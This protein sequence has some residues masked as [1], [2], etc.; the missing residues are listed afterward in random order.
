MQAGDHIVVFADAAVVDTVMGRLR[1]RSENWPAEVRDQ[2]AAVERSVEGGLSGETGTEIAFFKNVLK[3]LPT[4]REGLS[5]VQTPAAQV[6]LLLTQFVELPDPEAE[7]GLLF[8]TRRG[9][10]TAVPTP[11]PCG[12]RR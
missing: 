4:Y 9:V 5:A 1:D 8:P 12:R 10:G 6:G 2:F 3:Q 11:A 7:R